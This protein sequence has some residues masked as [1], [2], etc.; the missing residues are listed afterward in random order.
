MLLLVN[1]VNS[2]YLPERYQEHNYTRSGA[3]QRVRHID[4][5]KDFRLIQLQS[6]KGSLLVHAVVCGDLRRFYHEAADLRSPTDPFGV[7]SL[8]GMRSPSG[9]QG[10]GTI[11]RIPPGRYQVEPLIRTNR[12]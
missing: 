9:H 7:L 5:A 12:T 8:L 1:V 11:V 2:A 3:R 10:T 6:L 4:W